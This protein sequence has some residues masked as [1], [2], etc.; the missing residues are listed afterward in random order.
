VGA[1]YR[2]SARSPRCHRQLSDV[3]DKR[4]AGLIDE[5]AKSKPAAGSGKAK[6]AD[7]YNCFM[8]EAAVD[9]K[10]MGPI[11]PHLD[12]IAAIADKQQLA[13]VGVD[14]P[15]PKAVWAENGR[16]VENPQDE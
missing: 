9:A 6:I 3:S 13:A 10:G 4:T 2:D 8:D 14:R 5:I 11:K 16:E 1:A 15:Q 12:A 7:L